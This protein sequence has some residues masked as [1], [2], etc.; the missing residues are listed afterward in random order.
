MLCSQR[1]LFSPLLF[2]PS[3]LV[4]S[5]LFLL[6]PL[7]SSFVLSPILFCFI[8]SSFFPLVLSYVFFSFLLSSPL[9]PSLPLSSLLF[10]ILFPLPFFLYF[11]LLFLFS[12][13]FLLF[14]SF[15]PFH[16]YTFSFL[17]VSSFSSPRHP[18]LPP[19]P[20]SIQPLTTSLTKAV[21][22]KT[23]HKISF[24]CPSLALLHPQTT[25]VDYNP[26]AT[27]HTASPRQGK[28]GAEG[29]GEG[30]AL[31]YGGTLSVSR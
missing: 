14:S 16:S 30:V 22:Q 13:I 23:T 25:V 10:S 31:L 9:F 18:I 27:A 15:L 20:S 21:P 17:L 28:R 12:L 6:F 5:S 29:L 4:L 2:P 7:F 24:P 19:S 26:G 11:Y 3:F 1:C 8:F